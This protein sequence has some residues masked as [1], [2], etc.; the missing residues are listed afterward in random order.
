MW[1]LFFFICTKKFPKQRF[2]FILTIN[3]CSITALK[4]F[5]HVPYHFCFKITLANQ[6][7]MPHA[8]ENIINSTFHDYKYHSILKTVHRC[9]ALAISGKTK[10]LPLLFHNSLFFSLISGSG[11]YAWTKY[12]IEITLIVYLSLMLQKILSLSFYS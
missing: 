1:L 11:L 2:Y 4:N 10:N 9:V 7:K 3:Q 5:K 12:F 8:Y 6:L